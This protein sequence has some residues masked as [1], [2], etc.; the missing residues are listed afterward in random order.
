MQSK[1]LIVTPQ[2]YRDI[3]KSIEGGQKIQAIKTLK[4][5]FDPR[6]PL[7][8]AKH[9]IDR[10]CNPSL[11]NNPRVICSPAVVAVT[12]DYGDGPIQLNLE[13]MQIKVLTQL[14]SI[15]IEACAHMLDLVEVFKAISEGKKVG[16]F[17]ELIPPED[18]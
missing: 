9:A 2:T 11:T 1:P 6:L 3:V 7:K 8:E 15:G 4:D 10:M 17:D 18:H 12:L 5:S 14:P 13:E 16:V